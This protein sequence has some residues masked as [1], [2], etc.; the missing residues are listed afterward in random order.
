M[1]EKVTSDIPLLLSDDYC[2][3]H[4]VDE[5]LLFENELHNKYYYPSEL[6]SCIGALEDDSV[7]DKWISLEL[8]SISK[9]VAYNNIIL[10]L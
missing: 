7:I 8:K 5:L 4:T 3:S 2:F 10:Q 6:L 1:L 9:Y